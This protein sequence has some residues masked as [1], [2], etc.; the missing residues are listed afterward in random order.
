M[1]P[2]RLAGKLQKSAKKKSTKKKTPKRYTPRRGTPKTKIATK[3]GTAGRA[4]YICENIRALSE[5]SANELKDICR[6]EDVEYENKVLATINIAEKCA[7]EAYGKDEEDV[8]DDNVEVVVPTSDD[9]DDDEVAEPGTEST[10]AFR[11]VSVRI[12]NQEHGVNVFK[13][14]A[15]AEK[16]GFRKFSMQSEGGNVWVDGWKKIRKAFGTTPVI[17]DGTASTLAKCKKNLEEGKLVNMGCLRRWHPKGNQDKKALVNM[18]RNPKRLGELKSFDVTVLFRYFSEEFSQGINEI[19]PEEGGL[20]YP[21]IGDH[22]RFRLQKLDDIHPLL[23]NANNVP[24]ASSRKRSE[25]LQQEIEQ[26][27]ERWPNIGGGVVTSKEVETCI[28]KEPAEANKL[29]KMED[30]NQLRQ[31]LDGLVRTPLDRN[32]GETLV[33]C[34]KLYH[35]AMMMMFVCNPGY[36]IVKEDEAAI[37]EQ[38][39]VDSKEV[40][41]S[42]FGKLNKKGTFG[43]AY[44]QPKH[45][46]LDRYRP[47]CP[48]HSEPSVRTSKCVA[49]ALNHLLRNIP[50]SWHF[51]LKAVSEVV[52]RL[53]SMNKTMRRR[54]GSGLHMSTMS[55]DIKDMFSKLPHKKIIEA[56]DWIIDHFKTK[57]V[58]M[59]RVNPQGK[60]STFG[61]TTGDDHWRVIDLE[62]LRTFVR[63]D[64]KHTYVKATGVLIN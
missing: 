55:Y 40:G 10:L 50:Q 35:E 52:P 61:R 21:R 6:K 64:L 44:V 11:P 13:T 54:C 37:I 9:E 36:R 39:A 8:T 30:V 38:M 1:Q 47:I 57:G 5:F 59:V 27:F 15:E 26:A 16:K 31:R 19:L 34:P 32:T 58:K 60:G 3:I 14:L 24:Q 62:E 46:D 53:D 41:L 43:A 23:C 51:N 49:R 18:L 22:V 12:N 4:K 17:V 28:L 63:F 7:I 45:K 29:L 33:I 42:D 56:V 25:L 48:S 2:V 20:P